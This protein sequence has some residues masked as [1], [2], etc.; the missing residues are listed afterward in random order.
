M[1]APSSKPRWYCLTPDRLVIGLL[2]VEGLLWLSE[3]FQW[4]GFNHHKGC[5]ALIAAASVGVAFLLMLLWFVVALVFHWRFQFSIRS[6]LVL[7]VAVAIPCS[8]LSV[9]MQRLRARK[10]AVEEIESVGGTMGCWITGPAWVRQL[11]GDDKCFY[12]PGRVTLG[13][14]A[15][16]GTLVSDD[17]LG[18]IMVHLKRFDRLEHLDISSPNVTDAGLCGV[19]SL[20]G[21]KVLY[22]V[23]AA[24]TD[25][26]LEDLYRLSNLEILCLNG[27][28]VTNE[29]VAKLRQALPKCSIS[30]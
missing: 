4:F 13:F 3:R 30:K 23:Q 5:T 18:R 21:L 7:T 16:S 1:T 24:I 14:M 20:T 15:P 27:T 26:S 28:H 12:E 2:V 17:D 8:W 22:V 11:V 10:L 25:E 29:G 6:L 19:G 9:E